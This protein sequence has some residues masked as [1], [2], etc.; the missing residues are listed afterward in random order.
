M[1]SCCFAIFL[2]IVFLTCSVEL[3]FAIFGLFLV[4][5]YCVGAVTYVD[6]SGLFI[7]CRLLGY[8]VKALFVYL[9]GCLHSV[10]RYC[11]GGVALFV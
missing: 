4:S 6:D 7:R 9:V 5:F 3:Q 8:V 10:A 2:V 1:F 11:L